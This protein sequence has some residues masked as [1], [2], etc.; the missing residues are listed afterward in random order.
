MLAG[1]GS[2]MSIASSS[3][4][5]SDDGDVLGI[6]FYFRGADL[7]L[8]VAFVCFLEFWRPRKSEIAVFA[9]VFPETE[10][11]MLTGCVLELLV[12]KGCNR[13]T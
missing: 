12:P 5:A 2:S 13:W 8:F 7:I 1:C 11:M 4:S 9:V 3:A 10:R 6:G